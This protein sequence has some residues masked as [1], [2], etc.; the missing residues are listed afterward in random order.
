MPENLYCPG[1]RVNSPEFR[2]GY[3]KTF[4]KGQIRE[5]CE[6]AKETFRISRE[7]R[8]NNFMSEEAREQSIIEQRHRD[9]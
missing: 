6:S 8:A 3:D 7:T 5:L 2:D 9:I 1:L 4:R